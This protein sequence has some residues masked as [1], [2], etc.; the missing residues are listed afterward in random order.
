MAHEF[1]VVPSDGSK[2]DVFPLS[3]EP[4]DLEMADRA[5]AGIRRLSESRIRSESSISELRERVSTLGDA[6]AT[7][8]ENDKNHRIERARFTRGRDHST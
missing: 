8:I 4:D 7:V 3:R 5:Q 2:D 6:I 1:P